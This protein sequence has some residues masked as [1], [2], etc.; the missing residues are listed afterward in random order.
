VPQYWH[1]GLEKD[2]NAIRHQVFDSVGHPHINWS[3]L[4]YPYNFHLQP[5][6]ILQ[7]SF[8]RGSALVLVIHKEGK[9]GRD[10]IPRGDLMA[11]FKRDRTKR[12]FLFFLQKMWGVEIIEIDK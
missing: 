3:V 10:V 7:A 11:R 9:D 12:R 5:D 1:W 8:A 4:P 2:N 6:D